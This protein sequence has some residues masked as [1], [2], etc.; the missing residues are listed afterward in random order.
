MG[1]NGKG[2]F[3]VCSSPRKLTWL[4]N[5]IYIYIYISLQRVGFFSIV[6][7]VFRGVDYGSIIKINLENEDVPMYSLNNCLWERKFLST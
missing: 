6:M 4:A 7:L 5:R 3:K 2:R 1:D